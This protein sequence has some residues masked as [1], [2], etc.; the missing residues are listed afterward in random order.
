MTNDESAPN[1]APPNLSLR[2]APPLLQELDELASRGGWRR[3]D[4]AR[5]YIEEGPR[6]EAHAGIV[7]RSGP[8]GRRAAI[9]GG[10]DVWE[11]ARVARELGAH[12]EAACER[13]SKLLGLDPAQVATALS[14][15]E[16]YA[17]EIDSRIR[18]VDDM[19]QRAQ[20][21]T[22]AGGAAAR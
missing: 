4:V 1:Y 5:I 18:R 6:M 11:I 8:G 22:R 21:A 13:V 10:P 2:V 15:Y 19:A 17:E 14:Y 20:A 16:R 3:E 9:A 7:F 12:G